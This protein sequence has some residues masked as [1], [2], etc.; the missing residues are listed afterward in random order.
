MNYICNKD[1]I[2]IAMEI[3]VLKYLTIINNKMIYRNKNFHFKIKI[4]MAKIILIINKIM[5]FS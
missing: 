5:G 2:I 3:K 1:K 4:I